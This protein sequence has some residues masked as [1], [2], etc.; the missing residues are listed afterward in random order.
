MQD[1]APRDSWRASKEFRLHLIQELA[2]RAV[3]SAIEKA[4]GAING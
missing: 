4:G 2:A 1:V 3:T